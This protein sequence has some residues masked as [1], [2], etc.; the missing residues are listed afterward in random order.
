MPLAL[1]MGKA[2]RG[3]LP[4]VG[5]YQLNYGHMV[6]DAKRAL[7]SIRLKKMNGRQRDG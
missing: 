5:E 6:T 1:A 2:V 4:G 7:E 3:E